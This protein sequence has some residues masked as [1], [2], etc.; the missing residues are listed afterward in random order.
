MEIVKVFYGNGMVFDDPNS[1]SNGGIVMIYYV[2]LWMPFV[3]VMPYGWSL[4]QLNEGC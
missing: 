3:D 1:A 4:V 2:V